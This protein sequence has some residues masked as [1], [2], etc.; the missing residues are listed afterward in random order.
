MTYTENYNSLMKIIED[1]N[2]WKGILCS[3]VES[4][5]F[6]NVHTTKSNLQIQSV[7]SISKL[8]W[9]FSHKYTNLKF[10]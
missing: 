6:K 3:Y 9:H 5:S 10:V 4:L 1:T 8:Q 2:K 7:Q